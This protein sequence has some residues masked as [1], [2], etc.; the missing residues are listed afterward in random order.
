MI[1]TRSAD[2]DTIATLARDADGLEVV[3]HCFYPKSLK[4]IKRKVDLAALEP[5]P[6]KV[7][8]N[9]PYGV[10]ATVILRTVSD[11]PQV[12]TWVAMVQKEVGER[13]AARAGTSAYG[14]PSVLAQ[15][16]C[17]VKVCGPCRVPSSTP[18]RTSTPSWWA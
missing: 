14:V 5:A 12:T 4:K 16:A 2:D 1:H 9:L 7:V 17:D 3:L 13:F 8:A 10:A 18:C 15:L 6:T 11:L